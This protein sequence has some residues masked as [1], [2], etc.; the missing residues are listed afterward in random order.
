MTTQYRGFD[1]DTAID[2][3]QAKF[4]VSKGYVFCLRYLS[5]QK[6]IQKG[7]LNLNEAQLIV[8]N[9]LALMPVQHAPYCK[10]GWSPTPALGTGYGTNAVAHATTIGVPPQVNIW[11]DLEGVRGST[12]AADVIAYCSNWFGVVAAAGYVPGIYVG[13]SCGLNEEQL[14]DLPFQ[15]YWKSMSEDM[16]LS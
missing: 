10:G 15:H 1:T 12:A 13:D 14:S 6:D 7:D 16:L 3:D 2:A 8:S 4:F 11:M 5:L 9:G